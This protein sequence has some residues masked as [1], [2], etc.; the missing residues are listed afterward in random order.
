[1]KGFIVLL[2]LNHANNVETDR[3]QIHC[4]KINANDFSHAESKVKKKWAKVNCKA[5]IVQITLN[6]LVPK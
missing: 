2:Y 6:S 5:E 3:S 1:M 4:Q